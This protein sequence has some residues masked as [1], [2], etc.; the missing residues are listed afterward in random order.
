MMSKVF[1]SYSTK[2]LKD[3]QLVLKE[4][5][6]IG[7]P[8][9]I[10]P[11]DIPGGSDYTSMIPAAISNC[12]VMV[13]I[14]S[15]NAEQSNWVPL[16][17]TRAINSKKMIIPFV[18]EKYTLSDQ[19]DFQLSLYQ[20]Y[21]A[22]E[23]KPAVL[24][25]LVTR[26]RNLPGI[27]A[28]K[29]PAAAPAPAAVNPPPK[30][31]VKADSK[32]PVEAPPKMPVKTPPK[33]P[34]KTPSKAPVKTPPKMPA[35]PSNVWSSTPSKEVC[36]NG[37]YRH[38]GKDGIRNYLRF[39]PNGKIAFAQT[40]NNVQ[41]VATWLG[42][43]FPDSVEARFKENRVEAEILLESGVRVVIKGCFETGSKL[44]LD[45]LKIG[46]TQ[47][48]NVSAGFCN[49]K[50]PVQYTVQP[51][52]VS[53]F[54]QFFGLYQH[55]GPD[56]LGEYLRFFPDGRVAYARTSYP[57]TK[58]GRWMGP[59]YPDCAPAA[60][61]GD[62]FE[63]QMV[64]STGTSVTIKG[65]AVDSNRISARICSA[66]NPTVPEPV[67]FDFVNLEFPKNYVHPPKNL[68]QT[69]RYDGVYQRKLENGLLDLIRVMPDD[70]AVYVR[71]SQTA[72]EAARWFSQMYPARAKHVITGNDFHAEFSQ[73]AGRKT[74]LSGTVTKENIHARMT[75]Q[76]H[77][78]TEACD[79]CF[80]P[81]SF[82]EVYESAPAVPACLL[83]HD[84]IYY[85]KNPNGLPRFYRFFPDKVVV[86]AISAAA[87]DQVI[88]WLDR[89]YT[90]KGIY[91]LRDGTIDFTVR[92]SGKGKLAHTGVVSVLPFRMNLEVHSSVSNTTFTKQLDFYPDPELNA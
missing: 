71:T 88:S 26:I 55:I 51:R 33:T 42:P 14:L 41:E 59:Q 12:Q 37:I 62:H 10:A 86:S 8:C 34:A 61:Q 50:F 89:N 78:D 85:E 70:T 68:I 75:Y 11:R 58:A 15:R 53:K 7:I 64:L 72:E 79:Y 39:F 25:Q 27:A 56:G 47:W 29:E 48:T 44:N 63:S 35:A 13:L 30:A 83:R 81:V 69:A 65:N 23:N 31:P 38:T 67:T 32:A 17:V 5:E 46:Q 92:D 80:M 49:V 66:D 54:I 60:F 76:G 9:W 3:A 2:D 1:I 20:K 91:T 6:S 40:T 45:I 52:I 19:F 73:P 4:L 87:P 82:P 16:E 90:N 77:E 57:V 84:G 36:F 74:I 28:A 43:D 22:Y 24:K 21:E 18:V